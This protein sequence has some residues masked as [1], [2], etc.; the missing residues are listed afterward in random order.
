MT[1]IWFSLPILTIPII[2]ES[3]Y[4]TVFYQ[5][6]LRKDSKNHKKT[7]IWVINPY[8]APTK[9]YFYF[10]DHLRS[11]NFYTSLTKHLFFTQ[12]LRRKKIQK[13]LHSSNEAPKFT[14]SLRRGKK[15]KIFRRKNIQALT[16]QYF[17]ILKNIN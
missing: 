14:D 17:W 16:K 1:F 2:Q 11:P 7:H 12:P 13:N 6:H 4:L 8:E 10:T 9:N 3:F 15:L 5:H